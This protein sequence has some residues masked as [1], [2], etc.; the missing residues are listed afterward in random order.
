MQRLIIAIFAACTALAPGLT[1]AQAAWPDKPIRLIVPFPAGGQLDVVARLV[2]DQTLAGAGAADRGRGE[3]GGRRQHR[4]RTR[5]QGG[6]GR[7]HVARREPADDD[8]A[9]RAADYAALRS[10]ARFRG[11]RADRHQPVPVRGAAKRCR[12]NT[13]ADF[14]T[15]AKSKPGALSYAGS[16]R[17]TVVHLATELFMHDAGIK[18]EAIRYQGQ[19]SAIAGSHHRPRAVHDLGLILAEPQIE[20]RQA[21]GA[22]GA[23]PAAASASARR[24]H[25]RRTRPG[26]TGDD[27]T[28][29]GIAMPAKTPAAIVNRV[30]AEI[31]KV[32][33]APEVVAKLEIDGHQSGAAEHAR[34][35]H[36]VHAATTSRAGSRWSRRRKSRPIEYDERFE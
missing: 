19:P 14:V 34:G 28:W 13:L 15:Y 30:N 24:A 20:G 9:E 36:R 23:R 5:G 2:A 32:L 22:G 27:V 11:R 31:M 29:F 18:M 6:A 10:A 35:L 1:Q 33:A 7:L 8:P 4:H 21:Q 12:S 3:A 16:A 26:G 25:R 17:G